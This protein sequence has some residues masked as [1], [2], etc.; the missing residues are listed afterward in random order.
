MAPQEARR[1]ARIELG[2]VEKV[3][4][5]VRDART[6]AFLDSLLQDLR[7]TGRQMRRS[8]GFTAVAVLTIAL[9][10]GANTAIFTLFY[11]VMLRPLPVK[12]PGQ[13][14]LLQW[15]ARRTPSF[16]E[17]S[18]FGYCE[19]AAKLF[20]ANQSESPWGCSFSSPMFDVLRAQSKRFD[21]IL[22]FGGSAQTRMKGNGRVEFVHPETVSGDYFQVLG[23]RAAIG[24]LIQ[25]VDD[26]ATA[27]PV[28]VL[29]H[30][31]WQTAFGG[32]PS[33]VGRSIELSGV[34]FTIVGVVESK[35]PGIVPGH[36]QDMWIPRSTF[37]R[38]GSQVGWSRI[39]DPGN[40]WLTV[41]G[42][43]KPGI[44]RARVQAEVSLIFRNQLL[45]GSNPLAD[46]KDDPDISLLPA[47]QGLTGSRARYETLLYLLSFGVGIILLI[48]CANVA[49]LLLARSATRYKEMAV[50]LALGAA[51]RRVIRQLLTESILLSVSGGLCGVLIAYWGVRVLAAFISGGSSQDFPFSLAPDARIL[52]FTASISILTGIAAG[53]G[54]AFRG[55][56]VN[57]TR[58]LKETSERG[59]STSRAARWFSAGDALVAA[60]VALAVIVLVGAGL[61][62]R[63]I[64][65]LRSIN[66]GFDAKNIL[67]VSLNPALLDYKPAQIQNLYRDLRSQFAALPD[68]I[69]VSYSNA[70][71]VSGSSWGVGI[72]IHG[73]PDRSD[74]NVN[75]L[76]VGPDFFAT[77]R[78]PLLAGRALDSGD[79]VQQDAS[80]D[81]TVVDPTGAKKAGPEVSQAVPI[82]VNESFV[83]RYLPHQNPLGMQVDREGRDS[84]QGM[85]TTETKSR[86][87]QI[88]GVAA[89]TKYDSLKAEVQPAIFLPAGVERISFEIRTSSDP[90]PLAS[91]VRAIV[92][93]ADGNL[94]V[95][96]RTQS[97][98]IDGELSPEHLV[99]RLSTFFALLALL[100][101]CIGLYGLLAYEIA[102]RTREIGIRM[103]LGARSR[104]VIR[105]ILR[106]GIAV[107][108]AGAAIGSLAALALTRYIQSLLYGVRPGDPITFVS[109][110][111]IFLLVALAACYTP[112]RRAMRVDPMVALRYE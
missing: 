91:F 75:T 83:R 84:S 6:G 36:N 96:I 18:G 52:A 21:G 35:F 90:K 92:A 32:S 111:V 82:L 108:L 73:Q 63:T 39:G 64:E 14:V 103:A 47:Q 74:V 77:M 81:T 44:S 41:L 98:A 107:A 49:G 61:F 102:R 40:A 16:D 99:E 31:Y 88:V 13:L 34:P 58:A 22:A 62:I 9:G 66:P 23:V 79:F 57:L 45:H 65:N 86:D 50:R 4:E 67:L 106:Q 8:P 94:P 15:H 76:A 55:T 2:G 100:L 87:W 68:V 110:G 25:T 101:A 80:V 28:V 112:A 11:A 109:V 3:K 46:A 38:I 51:R 1:A 78:I 60:Q 26:S 72:H 27:S 10:I 95:G 7:F 24:R 29:S 48:A 17:Y 43:L 85:D 89:D 5:Q 59:S 42:R 104:D 19:A 12:D 69:S 20:G 97:E 71:L 56:D 30:G 70:A 105:M 33:V 54:P 53:L 37:P 93:R